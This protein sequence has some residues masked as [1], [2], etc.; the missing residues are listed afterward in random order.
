MN[1][2][3]YIQ[4]NEKATK[5]TLQQHEIK[6]YNHLKQNPKPVAKAIDFQEN[7]QNCV[8][9]SHAQVTARASLQRSSLTNANSKPNNRN[10]HKRL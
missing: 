3:P 2:M 10:I 1:I 6:K 7:N 4:I 5:K 8:Q 9:P